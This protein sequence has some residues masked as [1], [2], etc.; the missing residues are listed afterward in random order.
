MW[1]ETAA[2]MQFGHEKLTVGTSVLDMTVFRDAVVY[3]HA[4]TQDPSQNKDGK[5][6]PGN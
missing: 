3:S 2:F 4:L 1:L 5:L 6:N